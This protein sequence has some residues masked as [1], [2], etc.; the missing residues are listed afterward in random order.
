MISC[1]SPNLSI[2]LSVAPTL[3][4]PFLLFGGYFL[5]VKYVLKNASQGCNV[6]RL[7][8]LQFDTGLPAVAEIFLLVS[9][10]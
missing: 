7:L 4:V 10:R 2:A 9:V 1:I 8:F 6:K 5:N 3:I